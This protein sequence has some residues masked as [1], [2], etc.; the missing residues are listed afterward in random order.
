MVL[1]VKRII[2]FFEKWWLVGSTALTIWV[3]STSFQKSSISWTQQPPTTEKM[4]K[5]VKKIIFDDPKMDQNPSFWCQEGFNHQDQQFFW[6]IEA[7]EVID[8]ADVLSLGKLLHSILKSKE[9]A[10]FL[11]SALFWS[12]EMQII[13][14][15]IMKYHVWFYHLF[16]QRLLRPASATF[17]KTGGWNSNGTGF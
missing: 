3:S 14:D 13:F 16:C 4:L 15:W 8:T 6:W 2:Y 7:V 11:N 1:R 17:L 10:K 5:S 9:S 12:F